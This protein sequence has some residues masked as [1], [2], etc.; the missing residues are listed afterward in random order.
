MIGIFDSGY[1][2][3]TVFKPILTELPQYDYIYLGDS[4]RSPYGIHSDDNIKRFAEQ[5]VEYLFD[6]GVT[7]IIFACN[8]ASAVCWSH[9]LHSCYD[10]LY[11][12]VIWTWF[13][14]SQ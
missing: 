10:V 1:G 9:G 13:S 8:T 4:A 2:G 3:L 11:S 6:R 12:I 5:A 14:Y 7:L